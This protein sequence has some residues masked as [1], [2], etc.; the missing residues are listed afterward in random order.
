VVTILKHADKPELYGLPRDPK[1]PTS[2]RVSKS[3]LRPLGLLGMGAVFVGLVGHYLRFGPRKPPSP[4]PNL[5]A[6]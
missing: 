3:W 5:P 2:I 4:P 1:V 6:A